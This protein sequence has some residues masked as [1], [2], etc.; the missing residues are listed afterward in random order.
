MSE[1][2]RALYQRTTRLFPAKAYI[3]VDGAPRV[4]T[5]YLA[6][7]QRGVDIDIGVFALQAPKRLASRV[8]GPYGDLVS[9]SL[10]RWRLCDNRLGHRKLTI[11]AEQKMFAGR[12]RDRHPKRLAPLAFNAELQGQ[13]SQLP[14]QL[15][16]PS[17]AGRVVA[18]P[19]K[20]AADGTATADRG[21]DDMLVRVVR[22]GDRFTADRADEYHVRP[23]KLPRVII[24]LSAV[25]GTSA[26]GIR[27]G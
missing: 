27:L 12:G 22:I 13:R 15:R 24:W 26:I 19:V 14:L 5:L 4:G 16:I 21:G 1:R 17:V 18:D 10:G 6:G 7:R 9:G 2:Q 3:Q 23:L 20:E 11:W 8:Y 25:S